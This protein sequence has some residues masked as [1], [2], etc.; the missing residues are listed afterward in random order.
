MI[1]Q[2][3]QESGAGNPEGVARAQEAGKYCSLLQEAMGLDMP[4]R[5]KVMPGWANDPVWRQDDGK[6]REGRGVIGKPPRSDIGWQ[7]EKGGAS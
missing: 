1:F 5:R 2:W 7:A 3:Q 4:I 6:G